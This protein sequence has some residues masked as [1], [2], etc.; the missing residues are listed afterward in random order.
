[1][2]PSRVCQPQRMSAVITANLKLISRTLTITASMSA[3]DAAKVDDDD[4]N[5]YRTHV[6]GI[7]LPNAMLSN[8]TGPCSHY[9]LS[10]P[11][12]HCSSAGGYGKSS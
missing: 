12:S 11:L 6:Q 5:V 2:P 3:F 8:S 10:S 4:F 1:M 7:H 9:A